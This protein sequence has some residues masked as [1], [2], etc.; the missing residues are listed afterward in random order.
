M[1]ELHAYVR[2]ANSDARNLLH[3]PYLIYPESEIGLDVME[4][5]NSFNNALAQLASITDLVRAEPE[6]Y[7]MLKSP[8]IEVI[9]SLPIKLTYCMIQTFTG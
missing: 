1:K 3:L 9:V 7:E 2:R 6:Y 5:D 8:R 4:S